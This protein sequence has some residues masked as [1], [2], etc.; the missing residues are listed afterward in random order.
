MKARLGRAHSRLLQRRVRQRGALLPGGLLSS[1]ALLAGALLPR[2][3]L[4]GALLLGV[5]LLAACAGGARAPVATY[6]FGPATGS[7]AGAGHSSRL[8]LEVRAPASLD[9]PAIAYRLLYDDPLKLHHYAASRW[10]EAPASLLAHRLRQRLGAQSALPASALSATLAG[11]RA[12]AGCLLRLELREFA[13]LFET[14]AHSRGVVQGHATL[15]AAG[16]VIV[17]ERA[18]ASEQPAPH[19]GA[20]GGVRALVAASED[21]A[22]Q[23]AAWLDELARAGG[24]GNPCATPASR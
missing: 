2:A 20:G 7:L 3:L 11:G 14:P 21:L 9:S 16:P 12:G 19:A 13:Q 8:A 23:L 15:L 17:A 6:D 1:G 4:S 10:S 24:A 22:R 5:V 18:L